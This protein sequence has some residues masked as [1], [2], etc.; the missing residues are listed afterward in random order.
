MNYFNNQDRKF[1][2][3]WAQEANSSLGTV[4]EHPRNNWPSAY[5]M[6]KQATSQHHPSSTVYPQRDRC[7]LPVRTITHF[8]PCHNFC[9]RECIIKEMALELAKSPVVWVSPLWGI[10]LERTGFTCL[11]PPPPETTKVSG[12][13]W[14]KAPFIILTLQS[15]LPPCLYLAQSVGTE[16]SWVGWG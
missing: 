15:I 4:T 5:A 7:W 11:T 10:G 2:Y 16:G 13:Y 1:L 12:P 8:C 3:L 6:L 14:R 9:P